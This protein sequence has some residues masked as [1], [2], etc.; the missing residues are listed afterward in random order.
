MSS[1]LTATNVWTVRNTFNGVTLNGGMNANN[2]TIDNCA[3]VSCPLNETLTL[4]G[5]SKTVRF[6]GNLKINGNAGIN[7]QVLTSNGTTSEWTTWT[8]YINSSGV[9]TGDINLNGYSITELGL[10]T[11]NTNFVGSIFT[12]GAIT[13]VTISSTATQFCS[14]PTTLPLG[15]Y[16]LVAT[17]EFG[18]TSITESYTQKVRVTIG[19]G[20]SNT[21]EYGSYSTLDGYITRSIIPIIQLVCFISITSVA[22]QVNLYVSGVS[23][24][25]VFV[26]TSSDVKMIKI[27]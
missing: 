15:T 5:T 17:A 12:P 16:Y 13:E 27:C 10:P 4:G 23:T 7:K 14:F 18:T 6:N 21:M 22:Q 20:M 2:K 26:K 11:N 8:P 3:Q 9:P 24:V 25:G 1:I 19:A